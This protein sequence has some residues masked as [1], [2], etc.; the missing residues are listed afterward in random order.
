MNYVR[1]DWAQPVYLSMLANTG[2]IKC[3]GVDEHFKPSARA[4][5][6]PGYRGRVYLEDGPGSAELREW[7]PNHAAVRGLR[8]TTRRAARVQHGF[9]T[10]AGARTAS[11]RSTITG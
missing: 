9:P 3:Y 11:P 10:R 6:A 5:D 1:R 7:S 2:V 4:A 8:R